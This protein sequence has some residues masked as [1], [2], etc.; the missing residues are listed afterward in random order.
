MVLGF[1]Q[2]ARLR[3]R[4]YHREYQLSIYSTCA[5]S[6]DHTLRS[7]SAGT[8][9]EFPVGLSAAVVTLMMRVYVGIEV[10]TIYE[11]APPIA[12]G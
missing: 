11:P 1:G 4:T 12:G 2:L 8:A 9:R 10:S 6:V 3:F 5:P 7:P